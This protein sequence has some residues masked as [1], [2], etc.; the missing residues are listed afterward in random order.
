M[1]LLLI[2]RMSPL[3]YRNVKLITM[4]LIVDVIFSVD[5]FLCNLSEEKKS[6][7]EIDLL[8]FII[9]DVIFKRC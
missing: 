2:N 3:K 5:S 7:R 8:N 1:K 6:K 4:H 9:V